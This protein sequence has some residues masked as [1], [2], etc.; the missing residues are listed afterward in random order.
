VFAGDLAPPGHYRCVFH[1]LDSV[2]DRTLMTPGAVRVTD[3]TVHVHA[4]WF[5]LCSMREKKAHHKKKEMQVQV[6]FIM[7]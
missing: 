4:I 1:A 2:G 5:L 3:I 6:D 7:V